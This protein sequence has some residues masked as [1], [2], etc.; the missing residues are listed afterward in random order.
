MRIIFI[1]HGE[2]DYTH[3][4][5][6]QKGKVEAKLLAENIDFLKIENGDFYVSPMGRAKDTASYVLSKLGKTAV[7]LDWLQEFPAR[8]DLNSSKQMQLA[9]PHAQKR[10]GRYP[11]RVV[12]DMVPS[13]WTEIEEFFDNEDWKS[14][15]ITKHSDILRV[16]ENVSKEFDTL[17][18]K[19]GYVREGHHYKVEKE[20]DIT[21]TCFCH[22]GLICM[23]LSH[24]WSVSPFVLWHSLVLA[25]TSVS[26]IVTEERQQGIA[27][28]RATRL[29]DVSHLRIGKEEP[30]LVARFCEVYSNQ[31]QWH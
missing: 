21:I 25:P 13:Y 18:G 5:L 6:T 28:F 15:D 26:E 20:S 14:S 2:P 8:V 22:F 19:Y 29:G 3:D 7:T 27:Y 11:K 1:R 31:E 24:L 12:W 30:S 4:S 23:L 9:Y 16:Y 10:E 17:L